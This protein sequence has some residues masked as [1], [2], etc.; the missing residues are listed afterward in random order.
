[1]DILAPRIIRGA[2]CALFGYGVALAGWKVMGPDAI[3]MTFAAIPYVIT[4]AMLAYLLVV[5]PFVRPHPDKTRGARI[6]ISAVFA[7]TIATF[8]SAAIGI[9]TH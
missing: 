7:A 1:M 6:F 5:S 3:A 9:A 8:L 4:A 2:L